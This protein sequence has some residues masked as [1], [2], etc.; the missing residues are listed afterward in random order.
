[1]HHRESEDHN[2]F[3]IQ[4]KVIHIVLPQLQ[5]FHILALDF[6]PIETSFNYMIHS[7]P[8]LP[9]TYKASFKRILMS[10]ILKLYELG[11]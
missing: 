4:W 8:L 6:N 11:V 7:I 10:K 9:H 1:M 2:F 5:S 3:V